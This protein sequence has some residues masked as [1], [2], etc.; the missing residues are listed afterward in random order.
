VRT[1]WINNHQEKMTQPLVVMLEW[2]HDLQPRGAGGRCDA[3]WM[4]AES[5]MAHL[6]KPSGVVVVIIA[7]LTLTPTSQ[8]TS[9][10]FSFLNANVIV[11]FSMGTHFKWKLPFN[12]RMWRSSP[13]SWARLG[14]P[15]LINRCSPRLRVCLL[16]VRLNL[17][18]VGLKWGLTWPIGL[19][20][21]FPHSTHYLPI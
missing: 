9:A 15:S 2:T 16:C 1:E 5:F 14:F 7:A 3:S 6:R 21:T 10:L 17:T 8:F 4:F 19:S 20:V 18:Y 11:L 13:P 12:M